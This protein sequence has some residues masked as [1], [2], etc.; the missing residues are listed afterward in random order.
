MLYYTKAVVKFIQMDNQIIDQENSKGIDVNIIPNLPPLQQEV[1]MKNTKWSKSI[2][3]VGIIAVILWGANIYL[4]NRLV[5]FL[6]RIGYLKSALYDAGGLAV[7][8]FGIILFLISVPMFIGTF[9]R[10]RSVWKKILLIFIL[11]AIPWGLVVSSH[12][13]DP[14]GT[15]PRKFWF[16]DPMNYAECKE[17]ERAPVGNTYDHIIFDSGQECTFY[18]EYFGQSQPPL[19]F[20]NP[21]PECTK[22]GEIPNYDERNY[23]PCCGGLESI[24]RME[25][26]GS[27]ICSFADNNQEQDVCSSCGNNICEAWENKCNCG[28]D[29]F[30]SPIQ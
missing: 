15:F 16:A 5:N 7:A 21:Q 17:M 29:C 9:P 28:K 6:E 8:F 25:P 10:A 24:P 11:S 23:K 12:K 13:R 22:A 3:F 2:L 4:A 27:G 1:P 18:G 19:P 30:V 20:L 14:L 26:N